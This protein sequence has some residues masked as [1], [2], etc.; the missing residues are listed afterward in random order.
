MT[1]PSDCCGRRECLRK[2]AR[3]GAGAVL[4]LLGGTLAGRPSTDSG[5]NH[6]CAEP[7][8]CRLCRKREDCGLPAALSYR[9]HTRDMPDH[10]PGAR[11]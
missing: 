3:C 4:A 8:G 9:L 7:R 6:T 1:I 5:M 2:I 11:P 10:E